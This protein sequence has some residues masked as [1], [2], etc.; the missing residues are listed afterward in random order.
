[1]QLDRHHLLEIILWPNYD[2][3]F[4]KILNTATRLRELGV[5]DDFKLTIA[6]SHSAHARLHANNRSTVWDNKLLLHNR[7]KS[8]DTIRKLRE[9][10]TGKLR[11]PLTR[12]RISANS[13]WKGKHLS[14][15]CKAKMSAARLGKVSPNKGRHWKLVNGKRTY[16]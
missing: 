1:M 12:A 2:G 6:I 10:N 4:T 15:E 7:H 16:Y 5:Y 9:S 11:S 13:A 3:T 8:A 14:K